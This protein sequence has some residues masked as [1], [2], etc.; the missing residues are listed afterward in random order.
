[1]KANAFAA[2]FLA[3]AM[4][5]AVPAVFTDQADAYT[6]TDGSQGIGYSYKNL[7]ATDFDKL[8]TSGDKNEM[9]TDMLNRFAV[10]PSYFSISDISV[11]GMSASG[12]LGESVSGTTVTS[13]D[14]DTTSYKLTFKATAL[15]DGNP[16]FDNDDFN[17]GL[18]KEI[19]LEN[20]T[21]A[22]AFF[23]VTADCIVSSTSKETSE[24]VANSSAEFV[25]VKE[26]ATAATRDYA[27]I[28][29][30]YTYISSGESK[31]L[32]AN[33]EFDRTYAA[34]TATTYD[35]N[36]KEAKTVTSSDSCI[37]NGSV[38]G[39]TFKMKSVCNYGGKSYGT[40]IT[41]GD[42]EVDFVMNMMS[43]GDPVH[44]ATV[45]A[46]DLKAPEYTFYGSGS[47]ALFNSSTVASTDLQ[48]NDSLKAFLK[49][50]GTVAETYSAAQ[51]ATDSIY[52]D[53]AG[54]G[55]S[56][57]VYYAAIAG[58]VAA[59]ILVSFLIIRKR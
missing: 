48:N 10:N 27:K 43:L 40:D 52:D 32:Q 26:K 50:V 9:A 20:K 21:Q 15:S 17:V 38:N 41:L 3:M 31:T 45:V 7:S 57:L 5:T 19:G 25:L 51:S 13:L 30:K 29:V 16:L 18:I 12:Y 53:L 8:F 56:K 47:N 1:M 37:S 54:K 39:M 23:T 49:S 58:V 28:D 42:N 46:N 6:A 59:V 11:T 36:G 14:A 35:F 33:Y 24:Y 44:S 34:D 2:I 55:G 22:D 4:F